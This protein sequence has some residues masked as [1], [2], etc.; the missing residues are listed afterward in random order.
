MR[1]VSIAEA[2]R[3]L[4]EIIE[5]AERGELTVITRDGKAV[6]QIEPA[7]TGDTGISRHALPDLAKFRRSIKVSGKSIVDACIEERRKARA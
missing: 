7:A 4:T 6:A 5:A 3:Q 2:G 1:R